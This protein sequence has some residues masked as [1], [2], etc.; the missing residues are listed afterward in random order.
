MSNK[1]TLGAAFDA[2]IASQSPEELARFVR[3]NTALLAVAEVI[4]PG[5]AA[6]GAVV[7]LGIEQMLLLGLSKTNIMEFVEVM[8]DKLIAAQKPVPIPTTLRVVRSD[9]N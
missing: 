5:P 8:V 4:C 2:A 7:G 9:E 1:E 3:L 6:C